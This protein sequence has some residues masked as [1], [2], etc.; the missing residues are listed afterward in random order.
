MEAL[1]AGA[2]YALRRRILQVIR[3]VGSRLSL[4]QIEELLEQRRFNE[5][6]VSAELAAA[7]IAA[8]STAAF[9]RAAEDTMRRIARV[10]RAIVSFDQVDPRAVAAMQ[11]SRLEFIRDFVQQQNLATRLAIAEGISQNLNPKQRAILFRQSFGLTP[12]QMQAVI[13]YRKL[14]EAGDS[15]ALTRALR[16]RRFDSS[17][18]EA[19]LGNRPLTSVQI[20][21]MVSRYQERQLIY[22]SEIMAN[23]EA[24]NAVHQGSEESYRQAIDLGL[25][26]ENDL[27][28]DWVTASDERVRTSHSTMHGQQRK[29]GEPFISGAGNQLKYPGDLDAPASD[30]LGC[31]CIMVTLF[32]EESVPAA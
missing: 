22:R 7:G 4:D 17:V 31:R 24:L 6:L 5:A 10:M 9:V 20:D 30:T 32:A 26:I 3:D 11:R 1:L 15:A 13:N 27:T 12:N 14:L 21:Q 18:R 29:I 28:R 8:T 25:I 16:D 19:S 23:A 2:A